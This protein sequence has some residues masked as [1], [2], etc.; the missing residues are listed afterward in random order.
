MSLRMLIARV[1]LIVDV[2]QSG[3]SGT[4]YQADRRMRIIPATLDAWATMRTTMT[5]IVMARR[6]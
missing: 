2:T 5:M 6:I 1:I 4:I 3:T